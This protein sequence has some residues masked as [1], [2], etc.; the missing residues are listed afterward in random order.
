MPSF[1]SVRSVSSATNPP[2]FV[3]YYPLKNSATDPT[4]TNWT[5]KPASLK[6]ISRKG[7]VTRRNDPITDMSN[8]FGGN[9]TFNDPDI[10]T[11]NTELVTDMSGMFY[12][13]YVFNQDISSWNTSN[14]TSMRDMFNN[15]LAFNQDISGWNVDAVT[16]MG[17]MF[18]ESGFN[19]D[20]SN[21]NVSN[22]TKMDFM[23][24]LTSFNQDI[25]NWNVSNVTDMSSMFT[26]ANAF[27]QDL[28]W[29]DVSHIAAESSNFSLSSA[30]T[31]ANKPLWGQT[32]NYYPLTN[33]S[34]DPT[35]SEWRSYYAPAGG[36]KFK[37]NDGIYTL[38]GEPITDMAYMFW[39]ITTFNDPDIGSWDT[40]SVTNMHAMF[41]YS[42][43][44]QDIGD[45]DTSSVTEMH[46]MFASSAFNQDISNW[47][48]SS[49]TN[50]DRM[51]QYAGFNQDLR[52]WDV[53]HIAAEPTD[54]GG[55]FGPT[56]Y[57]SWTTK[58]LWGQTLN[59]YP[60]TN[61]ATDL[62]YSYWQNNFAPAGGY[63]FRPNNGIY[64]LPGEPITNMAAMFLESQ[65]FNDPD[66]SSWDV[67]TVTN[68][69]Q[70]FDRAISFNQPLDNWDVSSV[71]N[72]SRMFYNAYAF[73]Q[74]L[75]W[76]DI[77][78]IASEPRDFSTNSALD[79]VNKPLWGQT[80]NYYPL[81]NT[82]TDPTNST[83]RTNVG[84]SYRF[85]PNNG[86]Y[87]LPG[88]PITNMSTMFSNNTTFN[89]PDITSWYVSSV[90]DMSSM[91]NNANAFN[92]DIGN[93]D[94]SS[95]TNMDSMFRYLSG[96]NQDISNW[97]VGSVTS[98]DNM[99]DQASSFNQDLRWWYISNIASEPTGFGG[100]G[101]WTTKPLWGQTLNYYP[102]TNTATDPTHSWWRNDH[103]PAGGYRFR[104]NNGIYTLP[105]D[106]ITSMSQMFKNNGTFNDP[107]IASWD[108]SSVTT[109]VGVFSYAFAFNQD[110]G[111]WDVS[112]VTA[113]DLMFYG[114]TGFN[115]DIGNWD[116]SS[117]TNMDYMFAY[118][119][120]FN[121][122]LRWWDVSNIASEPTGFHYNA[123][124]WTTKP[125]WG[126]TFNYYPL[127]N[128]A[129]DP[130]Y[131]TWRSSYAPAG[132]YRFKPNDGIY[133]LPAEPITDMSYMFWGNTTFN[134][135]AISSWDVSTVTNMY[136]MFSYANAFNQPIGNWDV[137]SVTNMSY[138]FHSA[139]TFNQPINNWDVSSVTNMHRMFAYVN[140]NFN[141]PIGNWNVSSVTDMSEMFSQAF[142]FNQPIG[143]WNV[144][145]V[146]NMH[147]MFN[148]TWDFNQPIGNWD[149]SSVTNMSHMF[150]SA[151]SFNQDLTGWDVSNVTNYLNFSLYANSSWTLKP[152]GEKTI[153]SSFSVSFTGVV[154]P[155]SHQNRY[156][157]I[158]LFHP[159]DLGA[160]GAALTIDPAMALLAD[161]VISLELTSTSFTQPTDNNMSQNVLLENPFNANYTTYYSLQES[162]QMSEAITYTGDL[163]PYTNFSNTNNATTGGDYTIR[164]RC[165]TNSYTT[166]LVGAPPT[167][168]ILYDHR[169]IEF[170]GNYSLT[171]YSSF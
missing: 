77:S 95:V 116:V 124:G 40:S 121:Q 166:F 97:D 3:K 153:T 128:S 100:A 43:F 31:A 163:L 158:V 60:L 161:E 27:N 168:T 86:I 129:T 117:V 48:V 1:A 2:A 68:M 94:V 6:F 143:N 5:T 81:T 110:I 113:M 140:W 17:F 51:F 42:S 122:D 54:F 66:I 96:F 55:N 123:G 71:T 137:S 32:L 149:V 53:S 108:V 162:Q 105:G 109:M 75:R 78:N 72:M 120:A 21:W 4:A 107:D 139:K 84:I 18:I 52:W 101:S 12:G 10:G 155:L 171:F 19:Q 47:D 15:A 115:Q 63:R 126:Q 88:E 20:I 135:P 83:W 25:S 29:W 36:Y 136:N 8:M 35:H 144:S 14:V 44:N 28:R 58:P 138:M 41:V 98:M 9:T 133:T 170:T 169:T 33:T 73:N 67:S 134:D 156:V 146:T 7:F 102:L 141:Q 30:L 82:A 99:F 38:P 46:V 59:Y 89:D 85:R 147:R 103:A 142:K 145:S 92:Q 106:P 159:S 37:P 76:W 23:F 119:Y 74:D 151:T 132:G 152:V 118:G 56:G 16:D 148:S 154:S 127:T 24:M 22:V 111:N 160:G 65:G 62:T 61:T 39:G 49:V 26:S 13:N 70:T 64:T 150:E 130:T 167:Q 87:T 131:S 164:I 79:A 125:L 69:H 157:D 50:M 93:W 11:W 165:S 80:F 34:T 57:S 114:V 90:T 104:P 112:S 45:W 91:F